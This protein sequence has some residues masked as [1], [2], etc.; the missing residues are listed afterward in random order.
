MDD[1]GAG[2]V[3]VV[4]EDDADIRALVGSVLVRGGHQVHVAGCGL[5]GLALVAAVRPALVTLDLG[6]PDIDGYEV[7]RRLRGDPD[8]ADLPVLLLSAADSGVDPGEPCAYLPKPFR[9]SELRAAVAGMIRRRGG[10]A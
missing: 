3:V 5:E 1:T 9:S 2:P 4:I 6:L 8:T 7:L 10:G